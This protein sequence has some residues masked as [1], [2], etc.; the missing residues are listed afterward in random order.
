M[1]SLNSSFIDEGIA[2][3]AYGS[4]CSANPL[5]NKCRGGNSF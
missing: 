3:L 5:A 4:D 2:A 1:N